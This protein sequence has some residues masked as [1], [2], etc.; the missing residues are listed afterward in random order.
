M[1]MMMAK[2]EWKFWWWREKKLGNRD[3]RF[4]VMML[5]TNRKIEIAGLVKIENLGT[6]DDDLVDVS[7]RKGDFYFYFF[8]RSMFFGS[9]T[10]SSS[11]GEVEIVAA[12]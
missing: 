5:S 7:W 1:M 9:Q 12:S 3:Y 11:R 10:S 4:A 6:I 8:C 2:V